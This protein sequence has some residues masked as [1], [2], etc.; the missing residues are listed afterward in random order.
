MSSGSAEQPWVM[1]RDGCE[2]AAAKPGSLCPSPSLPAEQDPACRGAGEHSPK[3]QRA[4][5]SFSPFC[6][7]WASLQKHLK[8]RQERACFQGKRSRLSWQ[9][10]FRSYLRV[11]SYVYHS[12]QLALRPPLRPE[13][14]TWCGPVLWWYRSAVLLWYG[15]NP[16]WLSSCWDFPGHI[17]NLNHWKVQL[18]HRKMSSRADLLPQWWGSASTMVVI[19]CDI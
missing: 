4:H 7:A 13:A 11:I 3:C 1:G 19:L 8:K 10:G 9:L 16:G 6:A 17:Y 18:C 15:K 5:G 12:H 14:G 2:M